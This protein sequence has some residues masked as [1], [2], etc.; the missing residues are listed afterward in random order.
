M[1]KEFTAFVSAIAL[2]SG[3]AFAQD[4][5]DPAATAP[6]ATTGEAP[7][8]DPAAPPPTGE[9]ATGS[10]TGTQAQDD[11]GAT[12]ES[13]ATEEPMTAQDPAAEDPA[14]ATEDGPMTAE[15]PAAATEEGTATAEGEATMP[16]PS[17]TQV[18]VDEMVGKEVMGADGEPLGEVSDVVL[19]PET[20]QIVQ[21]VIASGGFLGIGA[22]NVAVD[23]AE[24]EIR[25]EEGIFL[26][27]I[28][29]EDI[30]QMPEFDAEA[31]TE[32]LDEPPPPA[33]AA[34][35][36]GTTAPAAPQ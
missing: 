30:T 35:T 20:N 9:D 29:Q 8:A 5:S 24:A 12:E 18:S 32:S 22:K 4:T 28:T 15:D 14:A 13:G 25:P 10:D 16:E 31:E 27:S 3:A 26:S 17:G 33:A 23:I 1:R 6:D 11:T 19:D 36:G 7:A 2:M 34:P 21:L